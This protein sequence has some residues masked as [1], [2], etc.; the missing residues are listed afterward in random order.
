MKKIGAQ[1]QEKDKEAKETRKKVAE[2][3][4]L[5]AQLNKK[6][7]ALKQ[8]CEQFEKELQTELSMREELQ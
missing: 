5:S 7:K 4:E 6:T 8:E 2:Q 3:N 1:I